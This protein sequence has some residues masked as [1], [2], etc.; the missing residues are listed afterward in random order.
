MI[1]FGDDVKQRLAT[2]NRLAI[3]DPLKIEQDMVLLQSYL[4]NIPELLSRKED[5][6]A[7]ERQTRLNQF[8]QF[9]TDEEL[10]LSDVD[11]I[12]KQLVFECLQI[13]PT[14]P[15]TDDNSEQQQQTSRPSSAGSNR[16]EEQL[17]FEQRLSTL[18]D[19]ENKEAI[20]SKPIIWD[21]PF[22]LLITNEATGRVGISAETL[23][24]SPTS[25]SNIIK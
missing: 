23:P 2:L 3:L 16:E 17:K 9:C 20:N 14:S 22:E 11:H 5:S 12:L 19:Q 6:D 1:Y 25:R 18:V 24:A 4:N 13:N 8:L 10:L 21:D 15:T 7:R